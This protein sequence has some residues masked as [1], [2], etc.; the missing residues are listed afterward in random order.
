MGLKTQQFIILVWKHWLIKYRHWL[1]TLF[2]L[3]LP[4]LLSILIVTIAAKINISSEPDPN[5]NNQY[6]PPQTFPPTWSFNYPVFFTLLYTPQTKLTEV[7]INEMKSSIKT[8]FG[9]GVLDWIKF[10]S[11]PNEQQLIDDYYSFHTNQSQFNLTFGIVF[12]TNNNSTFRYKLRGQFFTPINQLFPFKLKPGPYLVQ[13]YKTFSLVQLFI[14]EAFLRVY[15]SQNGSKSENIEAQA[16]PFPGY[17]GRE[18]NLITFLPHLLRHGFMVFYAII[19]KRL[20]DEK[21]NRSREMFKV[22]GLS[23]WIYWS[24][25]FFNYFVTFVIQALIVTISYFTKWNGQTAL[26]TYSDYT[27]FYVMLLIYGTSLILSAMALSIPFNKPVIAVVIAVIYWHFQVIP[28]YFLG[29]NINP[30]IDIEATQGWRI[31][32]C[33]LPNMALKFFF[34][35]L[36]QQENYGFGANWSNFL[37]HNPQYGSLTYGVIMFMMLFSSLICIFLLWYLD[38][39]WPWQFGTHKPFYFIFLPSYWCL[40]KYVSSSP[41]ESTND[42]VDQ[43]ENSYFECDHSTDKAGI[44]IKNLYKEFGSGSL[45]KVAVKNLSLD[46]AQGRI[47]ILLGQNGAGKSTTM[48]IVTGMI[49]PTSGTVY[50]NDYD[51]VKETKMA[52]KSLSF[53][54]QYNALYDELT[55]KEHFKLYAAIKGVPFYKIDKEV[56]KTS[57]MTMLKAFSNRRANQLSGGM[58]RKLNL[59]MAII[60]DTQIIVLDE[61]TSGLDPESR[62]AIWDILLI[63]RKER[64]IF[65]TTHFMEEADVLADTI[66]IIGEGE[67]K[68]Y[69]SPMF[70]KKKFS[71]GYR[72]RIVKGENCEVAQLNSFISQDFEGAQLINEIESE[73]I[74]SLSDQADNDKINSKLAYFFDRLEQNKSHFG[75]T[76]WG[77]SVTSLENVF[78]QVSSMN[79]VETET[80]IFDKHEVDIDL[81]ATFQSQTSQGLLESFRNRR[82]QLRLKGMQ[83]VA[84]WYKALFLKRIHYSKRYWPMILFQAVIPSIIFCGTLILDN[85]VKN[86]FKISTFIELNSESMYGNIISFFQGKTTKMSTLGHQIYSPVALSHNIDVVFLNNSIDPNSYLINQTYIMTFKDYT[87]KFL[88]GHQFDEDQ[89]GRRS[90]RIWHNNEA[91]HSLPISLNLLYETLF[92]EFK[93]ES[94]IRIK[95]INQPFPN[96][97]DLLFAYSILFVR[98]AMCSLLLPI[99][100]SF[101]AGSYIIFP[102]NERSTKSKFLQL[103]TG[104]NPVVYWISNFVFDLFTHIITCGMLLIVIYISDI[105]EVFT[106]CL[107]SFGKLIFIIKK[108]FFISS[109]HFTN[110]ANFCCLHLVGTG[111]LL[112]T[113]GLAAIPLS[114]I[115]SFFWKKPASGFVSLIT[116]YFIFGTIMLLVDAILLLLVKVLIT[117]TFYDTFVW[118]MD[119]FPLYSMSKGL[120]KIYSHNMQAQV[121]QAISPEYCQFNST[122]FKICCDGNNQS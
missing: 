118:I 62:R 45:K 101:I 102:L 106:A 87:H 64:T 12:E 65:L 76:S 81:N 68:C 38:A 8:L 29:L 22:I 98:Q 66:A 54:P 14:N 105:N 6:H 78:L 46:I 74:Y 120:E 26:I 7:T 32:S 61:P 50:I 107:Q 63:L 30:N 10:K 109:S 53:C 86:L 40:S 112:V 114:Y 15:A 79:N 36:D 96:E 59:G 41:I 82:S 67:L 43:N 91:I 9:P 28:T 117:Q 90:Y 37:E 2:E 35:I 121:C 49:T 122:I 48:N 70:L 119:F 85:Y 47:T 18:E 108:L 97:T 5:K 100:V 71:A 23:D 104:L 42:V 103:M 34:E 95:T 89:Y 27:F 88:T 4:L 72:L 44:L 16:F 24:S 69:G 55:V 51:I 3:L 33:F 20:V 1:A 52:R 56:D 116:L 31:L 84:A 17:T 21:A 92:K 19:V 80:H 73:L 60:G 77:L 111:L 13:S 57:S 83:L 94:N 75:V 39:I 25:N 58:K 113:F 115:C 11:Y 93:N 99:S 110:D